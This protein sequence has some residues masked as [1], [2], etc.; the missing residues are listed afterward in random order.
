MDGAPSCL[1]AQI[2]YFYA[3]M[4]TEMQK[5]EKRPTNPPTTQPPTAL[6]L[7]TRPTASDM[8]LPYQQDSFRPTYSSTSTKRFCA[9]GMFF[10]NVKLRDGWNAG[11]LLQV[12]RLDNMAECLELCC[13]EPACDFVMLKKKK[14]FTVRCKGGDTCTVEEGGE[15]QISFV[16][17]QGEMHCSSLNS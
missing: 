10:Y 7:P 17:R 4:S 5:L 11:M 15:Y 2:I 12:A 3:I 13:D 14:C 16:S 6:L 8:L 9:Q 1:M